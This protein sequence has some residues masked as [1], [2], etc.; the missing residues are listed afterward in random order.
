M[1]DDKSFHEEEILGKAYDGRLMRRLLGFLRPHKAR[2]AAAVA[3]VVAAAGLQL[4]GPYLTK[5]AIDDH[6][7]H[8]DLGGLA[9]VA[10]LLV[11]T[12]FAGAAVE[13]AELSLMQ[14]TGQRVMYDIR[15]RLFTHLQKL[16]LSFY[17]R[18]PVGR[19]MTRITNDV[20]VLNELFTSGV[21]AIFGDV[22]LLI[23]I[24]VVMFLMNRNTSCNTTPMARRSSCRSHS[25]TSMPSTRMRPFC[26]S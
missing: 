4:A 26:T 18:T 23:G 10:G 20:D 5:I 17:D 6:I 19:L 21:V 7:A 13:Y 1:S 2:V 22:F 25:R 14:G 16:S 24:V 12:M 11:L 9:I 8:G 3:L 15:M